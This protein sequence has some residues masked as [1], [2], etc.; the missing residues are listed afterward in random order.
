MKAS[1]P[2]S[3]ATR[4]EKRIR[5]LV[6]QS[7]VVGLAYGVVIDQ[8]LVFNG[9]Y[10]FADIASGR[11]PDS[12]TIFRCGSLTKTFTAT[13]LMQLRDEGKLSLD[14]PI[15]LYIPEFESVKMK[16]GRLQDVTL[17]RLLTHHSG[18]M[19]EA[20]FE[21]WTTLV[22]PSTEE[23]VASLPQIEVVESDSKF[24]YS[25]LGYS[26]LGEVVARVS[27]VTYVDYVR[28]NLLD[29]LGMKLSGFEIADAMRLRIAT[30]YQFEPRTNMP[31]VAPNFHLN[32]M[33][34][35]GQLYS[36]VGDLAKWIALQF[37]TKAPARENAQVLLGA[38]LSEMHRVHY[39]DRGW[40]WGDCISW[41]ATRHGEDIYHRH[42]GG[43]NGFTSLVTFSMRDSV[44]VIVLTNSSNLSAREEITSAILNAVIPI[45]RTPAIVPVR[46]K[47]A[48]IQQHLQ[49][50]LGVYQNPSAPGDYFEIVWGDGALTLRPPPELPTP[51]QILLPTNDPV[52]FTILSGK[53]SM[54]FETAADG[55]VLRARCMGTLFLKKVAGGE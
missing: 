23:I 31:I 13:A 45:A 37:R 24:K 4:I 42:G 26:L 32:G 38:S 44:G 20:P 8:E 36:S 39:L 52:L 11:N 5:R 3:L 43:I 6:T 50:F 49:R 1:T 15:A 46:V 16:F 19:A 14:A 29:P 18:L 12:A 35:A 9:G 40:T 27:G 51:T 30:G 41:R 7:G 22:F 21:H 34:S 2:K 33:A 17:R 55:I 10:G 48:P 54:L 25:N 28:R 47:S 53:E